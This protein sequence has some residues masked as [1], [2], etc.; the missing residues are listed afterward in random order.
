[1][2]HPAADLITYRKKRL[3]FEV[4]V[5]YQHAEGRMLE[6][7]MT[8]N[9]TQWSGIHALM[10]DEVPALMAHVTKALLSLGEPGVQLA[11]Q[12][13]D[14]IEKQVAEHTLASLPTGS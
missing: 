10:P 11:C 1:M 13:A 4:G 2:N 6:L 7:T 3:Q 14:Q 8:S 9:G 12:V 5:G